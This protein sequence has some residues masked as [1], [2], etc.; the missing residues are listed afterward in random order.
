LSSASM[1]SSFWSTLPPLSASSASSLCLLCIHCLSSSVCLLCL[2]LRLRVCVHVSLC[3]WTERGRERER[4]P[5]S[6]PQTRGFR[7]S[8]FVRISVSLRVCVCV[9]VCTYVCGVCA[10]MFAKMYACGCRGIDVDTQD[11]GPSWNEREWSSSSMNETQGRSSLWSSVD[12][13]QS[14]DAYCFSCCVD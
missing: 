12:D 8:A 2:R 5:L 10:P 6:L 14:K 7:L 4:A 11:A 13:G 3:V 1:T 9:L